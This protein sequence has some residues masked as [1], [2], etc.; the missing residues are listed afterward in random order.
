[1]SGR[2]ARVHSEGRGIGRLTSAA[3]SVTLAVVLGVGV[4]NAQDPNYVLRIPDAEGLTGG[5]STVEVRLDNMGGDIQGWSFSVC[6]DPGELELQEARAGSTTSIVNLGSEPDFLFIGT[7]PGGVNMLAVIC[8]EGCAVLG[9]GMDYGLLELDVRV[10]SALGDSSDVMLCDT[11]GSPPTE[12]LLVVGDTGVSPTRDNGVFTAVPPDVLFTAPIDAFG[13]DPLNGQGGRTSSITIEEDPDSVGFPNDIQGFSMAIGHDPNI[14]VIDLISEGPALEALD[15]G[16]GPDFFAPVIGPDSM[17]LG[18]VFAFL[19]GVFM[20]AVGPQDVVHVDYSPAATMIG[21]FDGGVSPLVWEDGIGV[22]PTD[23]VV[24]ITGESLPPTFVDGAM[25]LVPVPPIQNL[26]CAT[27]PSNV[28]IQLTWM[29]GDVYDEIR[30]RRNGSLI[31][32]LPG[33]DTAY[34]D[35]PLAAGTYSYEL[36]PVILDAEG[37]AADCSASASPP[38]SGLAC[39]LDAPDVSL[40]W[41][42]P[43]PGYTSV[44]VFRDGGEIASLPGDA[45]SY[46]DVEPAPGL[47][48]YSIQ[49]E[50]DGLLSDPIECMIEVPD[51][52]SFIRS[53]NNGDGAT[54]IADPIFNLAYL[55]QSGPQFCLDAQDSNDDGAVD[56]AD[57]VNTLTY[58]FQS[59]AAPP[60]PFGACGQD[61]TEDTLECDMYTCP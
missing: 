21:D 28:D 4:A 32:T 37:S 53:D 23:N 13:Y 16:S 52:P 48:T 45:T 17:T 57:P 61:P 3:M 31:A 7:Q 49:G 2:T 41:D 38:L 1:M 12:T 60:P 15:G 46:T 20:Q 56:I 54:D 59:G 26:V 27:Q 14:L 5:M 35:G 36:T 47:H 11:V 40:T 10:L 39:A 55:F 51:Q 50:V 8:Y 43:G 33:T 22:V 19:G 44:R 18:V 24:V 58:L 34:L 42:A 29:N 6:Y 25:T 30:V 9:A